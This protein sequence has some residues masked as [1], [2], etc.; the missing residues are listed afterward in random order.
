MVSFFVALF[1]YLVFDL[2]PHATRCSQMLRAL[3]VDDDMK[4][5]ELLAVRDDVRAS[6]VRLQ[7]QPFKTLKQLTTFEFMLAHQH[8]RLEQLQDDAQVCLCTLLLRLG[9]RCYHRAHLLLDDR[10]DLCLHQAGY[11]CITTCHGLALT[12]L[13]LLLR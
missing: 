1:V 11:L 5:F 8:T 7:L 10:L 6:S 13:R 3:P 2:L 4:S 12:L 9:Q